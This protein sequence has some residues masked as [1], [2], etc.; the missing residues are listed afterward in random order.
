M[1]VYYFLINSFLPRPA[2]ENCVV[3]TLNPGDTEEEPCK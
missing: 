3:S 2:K 1:P